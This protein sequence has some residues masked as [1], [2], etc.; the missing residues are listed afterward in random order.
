MHRRAC[1]SLGG[2]TELAN[3]G[4]SLQAWVDGPARFGSGMGLPV[5]S[6]VIS[7]MALFL[8]AALARSGPID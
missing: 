8:Q 6:N 1:E 5:P 2:A 4:M 7:I 3:A